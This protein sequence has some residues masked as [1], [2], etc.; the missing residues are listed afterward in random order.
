MKY[1][2]CFPS[3]NG[4]GASGPSLIICYCQYWYGIPRAKVTWAHTSRATAR[5]HL[6]WRDAAAV[7]RC[8]E[9]GK[10]AGNVAL[11][12]VTPRIPAA[13]QT[14]RSADCSSSGHLIFKTP[15]LSLCVNHLLRISSHCWVYWYSQVKN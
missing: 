1:I 3:M 4:W 12:K 8:G 2:Y 6:T 11:A 9:E 15:P 7:T 10:S 13:V 14:H 5:R